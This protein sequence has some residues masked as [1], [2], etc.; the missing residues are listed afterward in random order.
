MSVSHA[1]AAGEDAARDY[2]VKVANELLVV[3]NGGGA[4]TNEFRQL[5]RSHAAIKTMSDFCLGRY[6]KNMSQQQLGEYTAL[7][8][9]FIVSLFR[10]HADSFKGKA[11]SIYSVKARTPSDVT[12]SAR[13]HLNSGEI[14]PIKFRVIKE[15]GTYKIHDINVAGIWL[16]VQMRNQFVD[17]MQQSKGD[18]AALISYLKTNS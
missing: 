4:N 13:V 10:K 11:L 8:E 12:V 7:V 1:R 9:D 6:R 16:V 15:G 5:F 14:T 17:I 18:G 2:V 3:V